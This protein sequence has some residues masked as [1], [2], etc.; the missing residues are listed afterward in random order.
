MASGK[1]IN[2]YEASENDLKSLDG[3][4]S[5]K[6]KR[7]IDLRAAKKVFTLTDV[8]D[9]TQIAVEQWNAWS[10]AGVVTIDKP[11]EEVVAGLP[12]PE[13]SETTQLHLT[14]LEMNKSLQHL[15]EEVQT[16]RSEFALKSEIDE[17]VLPV[18]KTPIA[19]ANGLHASED[20]SDKTLTLNTETIKTPSKHVET[21]IEQKD[22]IDKLTSVIPSSC[23]ISDPFKGTK[24]KTS[25][26]LIGKLGA[27]EFQDLSTIPL[28]PSFGLD[29]Q[30]LVCAVW[31]CRAEKPLQVKGQQTFLG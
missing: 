1:P 20:S 15:R 9:A 18:Y 23:Y 28:N 21:G 17:S 7:I 6:A 30:P 5:A 19:Q 31:R 11:Q 16:L 2:L 29:G 27:A 4:G 25:T 22:I 3:I 12:T 26:L 13:P 10:K 8:A 14:L 24:P